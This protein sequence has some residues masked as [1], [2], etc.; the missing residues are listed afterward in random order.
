MSID[1][2]IRNIRRDYRMSSLDE[3]DLLSSPFQMFNR[4][5]DEAIKNELKES[6]AFVLSTVYEGKPKSRVVLLKQI[7]DDR[8]LFFTNYNSNK[9]KE[10]GENPNVSMTFFWEELQRQV[11]IEGI[12]KKSS[13]KVSEEY[14]SMRARDSQIAAWVSSQS[15]VM[16]KVELEDNLTFYNNKFENQKVPKPSH[17]GAYEITP[18]SIEFW[19]GG[20]NRLHNR[21][22]YEL[23]NNSWQIKRLGP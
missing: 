23:E 19:Q 21:F 15:Q 12:A 2:D 13:E 11:R 20:P 18:V 4:W 1:V 16:T 10:I 8:F 14:F 17:W 5:L 22:L 9:G 6:N 3:K 7:I